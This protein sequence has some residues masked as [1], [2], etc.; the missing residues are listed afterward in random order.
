LLGGEP[1]AA[2]PGARAALGTTKGAAGSW[3]ALA[4]GEANVIHAALA[5]QLTRKT[6]MIQVLR[7]LH[8]LGSV[9]NPPAVERLGVIRAGRDVAPA[10]VRSSSASPGASTS[11]CWRRSGSTRRPVAA[12]TSS[13]SPPWMSRRCRHWSRRLP[14]PGRP[15][16]R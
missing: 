6:T 3:W 14:S 15:L 10:R 2:G 12:S 1:R 16:R 4:R 5:V 13:V 9:M 8:M 7:L 11:T